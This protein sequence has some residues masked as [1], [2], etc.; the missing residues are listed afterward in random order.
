MAYVVTEN[1]IRCKDTDCVEVCPVDC[2]YLGETML[3]ID[4]HEVLP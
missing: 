2:V 3:V 1:G 4:R